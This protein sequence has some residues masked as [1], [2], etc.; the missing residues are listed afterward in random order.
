[1]LK[2]NPLQVHAG[3]CWELSYE[4]AHNSEQQL[5]PEIYTTPTTQ[6]RTQTPAI[7]AN[8][9]KQQSLGY[10]TSSARTPGIQNNG[11][12]QRGFTKTTTNV[13]LLS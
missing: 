11:K 6:N 7:Y 9:V 8:G 5:N 4:N 1:M 2:R 10:A 3:M 13:R 12:P